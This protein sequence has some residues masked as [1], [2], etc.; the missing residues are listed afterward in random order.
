[1]PDVIRLQKRKAIGDTIAAAGAGL[2]VAAVVVSLIVVSRDCGWPPAGDPNYTADAAAASD[3]GTHHLLTG[4]AISAI[5]AG[6]MMGSFF[7]QGAIGPSRSDLDELVSK[8]NRL[9]PRRMRIRIG[10]DPTRS[11]PL[12]GLAFTF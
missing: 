5:G 2:F 10:Y 9:N 8:H 11:L 12:T 1:M 3:C 7:A 6:V 4:V